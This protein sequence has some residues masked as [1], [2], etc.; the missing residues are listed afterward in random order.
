[1]AQPPPPAPL[2]ARDPYGLFAARPRRGGRGGGGGGHLGEGT[3]RTASG[4]ASPALCRR[5]STSGAKPAGNATSSGSFPS[6]TALTPPATTRKSVPSPNGRGSASRNRTVTS[7][8]QGRAPLSR[9]NAGN[10]SM[11]SGGPRSDGGTANECR[12]TA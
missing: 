2:P 7:A 8:G 5:S 6:A 1:L 3:R 12:P 11:V 10:S 4:T 9:A